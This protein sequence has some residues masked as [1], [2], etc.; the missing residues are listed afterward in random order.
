MERP[1]GS[2][3]QRELDYQT[4]QDRYGI[5]RTTIECFHVGPYRYT[6]LAEAIAESERRSDAAT[7]HG[8]V[9]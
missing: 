2:R 7:T 8:S 5:V 3:S 6:S 4:L 9:V 1:E